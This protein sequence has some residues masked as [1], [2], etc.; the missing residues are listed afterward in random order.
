VMGIRMQAP[1]LHYS[2]TPSLQ[3]RFHHSSTPILHHSNYP[4]RFAGGRN[5]RLKTAEVINA[6]PKSA[7]DSP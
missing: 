6:T 5:I 2:N 1:I 3:F 7:N 4:A